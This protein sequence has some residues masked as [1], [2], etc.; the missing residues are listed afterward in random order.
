MY[1]PTRFFPCMGVKIMNFSVVTTFHREG[2]EKYGRRM[3]ETFI[4]NWPAE[5]KLYVYSENCEV[6]ESAPNLVVRDLHQCSAEL[7]NLKKN[8]KM[9]QKPMVMS[10]MT[11][12]EVEEKMQVKDLSGMP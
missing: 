5:V 9:F 1:Q 3:I 7:V 10:A 11:L 4:K 6:T 12:L 2:Y 8:G